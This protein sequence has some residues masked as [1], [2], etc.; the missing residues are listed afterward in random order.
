MTADGASG[1]ERGDERASGT[2]AFGPPAT[3]P[4]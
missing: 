1:T 4:G 2:E 3:W